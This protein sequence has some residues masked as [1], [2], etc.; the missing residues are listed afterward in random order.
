MDD[1][2]VY[3]LTKQI[4]NEAL[5][6]T[7]LASRLSASIRSTEKAIEEAKKKHIK[8]LSGAVNDSNDTN[9]LQ[10]SGFEISN[11]VALGKFSLVFEA[12]DHRDENKKY[13]LKLLNGNEENHQY[14]HMRELFALQFF[15]QKDHRHDNIIRFHATLNDMEVNFLV[16]DFID[17]GCLSEQMAR[18]D[19]PQMAV[20]TLL[21]SHLAQGIGHMHKH[22]FS[23]RDLKLEN[24]L[25][26]GYLPS[27]DQELRLIICDF[28]FSTQKNPA[29]TLC[30][31]EY[32]YAP[33]LR[34]LRTSYN[35]VSYNE[36]SF[37]FLSSNDVDV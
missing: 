22:G 11:I 1:L 30:G 23:H 31:S 18:M 24:L 26:N 28:G 34:K 35:E 9:L 5:G 21:L 29:T 3:L 15:G 14:H 8:A 36:V 17:G 27:P 19:K 20:I 25:I 12:K 33:E 16:L 10:N 4:M 2:V 6:S 13:A 7:N 32:Y 37:C